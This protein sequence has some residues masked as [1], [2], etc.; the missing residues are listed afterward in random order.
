[1][2]S[3]AIRLFRIGRDGLTTAMR[4]SARAWKKLVAELGQ[5]VYDRP[6]VARAVERNNS[7]MLVGILATTHELAAFSS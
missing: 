5:S 2:A 3:D 6:A 7:C 1:M 4:R